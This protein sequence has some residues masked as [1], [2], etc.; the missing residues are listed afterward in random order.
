MNEHYRI[1][2]QPF[3]TEKSTL[4]KETDNTIVLQVAIDATKP[5]IKA[6]VE[7][8]FNVE[9]DSVNIQRL[10]GKMKRRGRF[11]GRRAERK[12]AFIK[13]KAGQKAPEFFEST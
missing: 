11:V 2:R 5:M 1:I 7:A 3:I 6:A 4:I 10:K 8:V 9:V 12:K 13:L